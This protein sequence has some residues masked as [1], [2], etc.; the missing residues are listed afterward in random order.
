M[1]TWILENSLPP[2]EVVD[3]IEANHDD[4]SI[5]FNW[6]NNGYVISSYHVDNDSE[7]K[8]RVAVGKIDSRRDSDDKS[9]ILLEILLNRNYQLIKNEGGIEKIKAL[10]DMSA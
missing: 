4:S 3:I 6:R 1:L 7:G 10:N 2:C 9:H 8:S 5:V